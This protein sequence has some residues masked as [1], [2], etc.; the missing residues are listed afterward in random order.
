MFKTLKFKKKNVRAGYLYI[1]KS[2]TLWPPRARGAIYNCFDPLNIRVN[3]TNFASSYNYVYSLRFISGFMCRTPK[4]ICKIRKFTDVSYIIGNFIYTVRRNAYEEENE[5]N[6]I[7]YS[8]YAT[9]VNM[10][11][12]F[13]S[14]DTRRGAMHMSTKSINGFYKR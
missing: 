6:I 9:V 10:V 12:V 4:C 1:L 3:F 14:A 7:F 5:Y 8:V 2:L 13:L 11:M